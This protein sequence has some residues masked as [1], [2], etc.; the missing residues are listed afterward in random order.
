VK[1]EVKIEEKIE[2]KIEVGR[3]RKSDSLL[4]KFLSALNV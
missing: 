1:I 3:G 2:E 4:K